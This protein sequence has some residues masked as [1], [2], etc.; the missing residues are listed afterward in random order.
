MAITVVGRLSVDALD[1]A[2]GDLP[3]YDQVPVIRVS[4]K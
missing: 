3:G 4:D 2:Q 1:V